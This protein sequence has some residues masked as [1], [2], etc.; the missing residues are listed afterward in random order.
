MR[1]L[2]A[3]SSALSSGEDLFEKRYLFSAQRCS[4]MLM[5]L[6]RYL[7]LPSREMKNVGLF[8][9]SILPKT[10][11]RSSLYLL[12]RLDVTVSQQKGHMHGLHWVGV[13]V[14][15]ITL[16]EVK[17]RSFKTLCSW[18]ITSSLQHRYSVLPALSLDG[19]LHL[20][21]QSRSYTAELFNDFID[22]LLDNMN[23]FPGRNSVIIM[24]NASI[25][26]SEVLRP[27][28]EARYEYSEHLDNT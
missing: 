15:G 16:S 19:V 20:N 14:G 11:N 3:Q 7:L 24:D 23:P 18:F 2:K 21:V 6:L 28:I 25:H 27:M 13:P 5:S 17:S 1:Y 22:G 8:I 4:D 12:M 26:K 9:R 10:M